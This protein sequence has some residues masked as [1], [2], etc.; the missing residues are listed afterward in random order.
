MRERAVESSPGSA[1]GVDLMSGHREQSR[2][3][4]RGFVGAALTGSAA[5]GDAEVKIYVG[6]TYVGRITNQRTGSEVLD[7]VDWQ[8]IGRVIPPGENLRA[9]ISDAGATNVLIFHFVTEP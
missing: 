4:A 9:E 3:F 7:V 6:D 1:V 2:G 5:A 8:K